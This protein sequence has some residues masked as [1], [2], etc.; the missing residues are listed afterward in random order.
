MRQFYFL[1]TSVLLFFSENGFA[2]LTNGT[3]T[4]GGYGAIET[5]FSKIHSTSQTLTQVQTNTYRSSS[6]GS[7]IA[8]TLGYY[9]N[10]CNTV[11]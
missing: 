3:K 9:K 5:Y 11:T 1:L 4:L 2:Q 7:S 6:F 8:P 10:R